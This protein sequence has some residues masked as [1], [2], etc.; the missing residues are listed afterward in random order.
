[1]FFLQIGKE[2]CRDSCHTGCSHCYATCRLSLPVIQ[3]LW[4][5]QLN[6]VCYTRIGISYW[7]LV[8]CTVICCLYSAYN[9]LLIH[10]RNVSSEKNTNTIFRYV[11]YSI[12][13]RG[14]FSYNARTVAICDLHRHKPPRF[15]R[16][17]T[18]WMSTQRYR[19]C[20]W[21]F[22]IA[23]WFLFWSVADSNPTVD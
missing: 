6:N 2:I 20:S 14:L 22:C 11:S 5:F 7:V 19:M 10:Q 15:I 18:T 23:D 4:L 3:C 1:M 16:V 12:L 21:T 8:L 9:G 13:P 17:G